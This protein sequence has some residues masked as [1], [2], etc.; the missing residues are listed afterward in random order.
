MS[1]PNPRYQ[2]TVNQNFLDPADPGAGFITET[3]NIVDTQTKAVVWSK[4]YPRDL[5]IGG[6]DFTGFLVGADTLAGT[7][8]TAPDVLLGTNTA[9]ALA[10]EP[11]VAYG[12]ALGGINGLALAAAALVLW[13]YFKRR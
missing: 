5:V 12:V 7:L 8:A 9:A 2:W 13:F 10:S 4:T 1:T 6:Q 3:Y 11:S